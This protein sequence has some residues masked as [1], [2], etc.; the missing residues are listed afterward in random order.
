MI[1]TT[2]A[3]ADALG[4]ATTDKR[5]DILRRIGTVG[6]ISEA[7]RGAG[8][9]Y[10]VSKRF[11]AVQALMDVEFSVAAGEV[12]ARRSPTPG[13]GCWRRLTSSKM[14]VCE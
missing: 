6:S 13:G 11:G 4:H 14:H 2:P 8:V 7:A 1:R 10:G 5:I 9:S 12:V 3:L